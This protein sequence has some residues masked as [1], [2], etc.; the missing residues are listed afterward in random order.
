[1]V[2]LVKIPNVWGIHP[3][4]QEIWLELENLDFLQGGGRKL[5]GPSRK[6]KG[7]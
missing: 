5:K 7:S 3:K 6:L 2:I 1:M 4:H